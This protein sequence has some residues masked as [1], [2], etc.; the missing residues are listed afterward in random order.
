[1][2]WDP[3]DS[4]NMSQSTKVWCALRMARS[5]R[6]YRYHEKDSGCQTRLRFLFRHYSVG[7]VYRNS[8]VFLC[9]LLHSSANMKRRKRLIPPDLV[10]EASCGMALNLPGVPVV[11]CLKSAIPGQPAAGRSSLCPRTGTSKC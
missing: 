11:E 9:K 7:C 5:W 6:Y 2:S 8:Q 4:R 1:M 10:E 3:T